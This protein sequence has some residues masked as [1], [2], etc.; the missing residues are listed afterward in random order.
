MG[1]GPEI[2]KLRALCR[3]WGGDIVKMSWPAWRKLE[4]TAG[5]QTKPFNETDFYPSPVNSSL[6]VMWLGRKVVFS[7]A[8]I[9]WVDVIHE[10]AHLFAT[11]E[12]PPNTMEDNFLGW[13]WQVAKLVGDPKQWIKSHAEFFVDDEGDTQLGGM[14]KANQQKYLRKCVAE[15]KK[16][17]IV[18]RRGRPL[19]LTRALGGSQIFTL[20]QTLLTGLKQHRLTNTSLKTY[21]NFLPNVRSFEQIFT[22][23][24]LL[25]GYKL[26]MDDMMRELSELQGSK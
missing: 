6:G 13:E 20:H 1:Q 12:A 25:E 5:H 26:A 16:A 8:A 10:M 18:D 14:S 22:H 21:P 3:Q 24:G 7:S 17:G 11:L 19:A 2:Q 15:S 23:D 4:D 9:S